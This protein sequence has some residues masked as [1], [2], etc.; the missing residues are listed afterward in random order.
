MS[1]LIRAGLAAA[2]GARRS[3][4]W[5]PAQ[6]GGVNHWLDPAIHVTGSPASAMNDLIVGGGLDLSQAVSGDR[7][8][9]STILGRVATS[10]TSSAEWL[11]GTLPSSI[12]Q[13]FAVW[14]VIGLRSTANVQFFYSANG[15]G[16][17]DFYVAMNTH[18]GG[19]YW[20]IGNTNAASAGAGGD[21]TGNYAVCQIFNGFSSQIYV[22]DFATPKTTTNGVQIGIS[23]NGTFFLGADFG[24]PSNASSR[25]LQGSFVISSGIPS[26]DDRRKTGGYFNKIYPG[27]GVVLP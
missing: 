4:I 21:M 10:H 20:Q 15:A 3:R 16:S 19:W 27:L 22:N 25:A 11:T 6:L 26:T 7:P 5:T 23:L 8:A 9:L 18:F 12:A 14:Y 13:P 17:T 24:T 1:A 2:Q